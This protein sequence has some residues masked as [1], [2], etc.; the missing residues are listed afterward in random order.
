MQDRLPWKPSVYNGAYLF[1]FLFCYFPI[2]ATVWNPQCEGMYI[3]HYP[4]RVETKLWTQ[5]A[6][7][8]GL[9]KTVACILTHSSHSI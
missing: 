2:A 6:K 7:K 5:I 4:Q 1:F 3:A 9:A 8:C